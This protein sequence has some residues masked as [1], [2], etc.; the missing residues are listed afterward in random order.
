MEELAHIGTVKARSAVIESAPIGPAQRRFA[1]AACAL[2]SDS[3]PLK[4]LDELKQIE[5]IFG[6]RRGRTWGDR[7][8]DLDIV[9]WSGSA[10]FS[11][12]LT[13]PHKEM[14]NRSFVLGPASTIAA[15]WRHSRS[16]L[17]IRQL[18]MRAAKLR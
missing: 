18:A 14:V 13:I 10:V 7:V 5:Q 15:D 11:R 4:L 9:M 16:G 6:R 2:V 1:N 12:A 3:K 8:L 17:T